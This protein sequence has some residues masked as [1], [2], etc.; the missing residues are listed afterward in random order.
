VIGKIESAW[1][2]D[3]EVL[4]VRQRLRSLKRYLDARKT[5]RDGS[6]YLAAFFVLP[7]VRSRGAATSRTPRRTPSSRKRLP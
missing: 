1:L 3:D 2:S 4:Y 6:L 7:V 5:R